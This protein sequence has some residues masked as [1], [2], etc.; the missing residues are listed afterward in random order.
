M[1]LLKVILISQV[2]N[3]ILLPFVLVFMLILV[4]RERLMGDFRNGFWGNAIAWSTSVTMV[5]L[6]IALI[7][8][9]IT[10]A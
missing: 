7:Y 6:T 5:L 10:G 1:P 9:S 2:A 8:N 4:N 3:G